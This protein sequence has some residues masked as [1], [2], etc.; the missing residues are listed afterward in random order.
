MQDPAPSASTSA[1]GRDWAAAWLRV[2]P[3]ADA[4]P[5]RHRAPNHPS[6]PSRVSSSDRDFRDFL[7]TFGASS[8]DPHP[9]YRDRLEDP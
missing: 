3:L 9:R 8:D 6:G 4:A 5:A 7:D 1:S 2:R